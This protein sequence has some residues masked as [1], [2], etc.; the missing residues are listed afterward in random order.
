MRTHILAASLVVCLVWMPSEAAAVTLRDVVELTRAG[1]ADDVIIALIEADGTI[2]SLNAQTVVQLR[3]DGVSERVI[4]AMLKSGRATPVASQASDSAPA[5]QPDPAPDPPVP[6]V[7]VIDHHDEL[8][9]APQYVVVPQ[10]VPVPV[11]IQTPV[12]VPTDHFASRGRT[13]RAPAP[14]TAGF[15]GRFVNDGWRPATHD[16]AEPR[17]TVYWGFGGQ[18]RPGS[19]D[20]PGAATTWRR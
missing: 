18:R 10:Y 16:T 15:F 6:Q 7:I 9:R 4:V 14:D 19:W 1:L 8:H 3:R 17:T 2:F 12:F 20:P 13:V 5:F 11:Y